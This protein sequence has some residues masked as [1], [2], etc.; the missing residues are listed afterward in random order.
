[1]CQGTHTG[2]QGA[3]SARRRNLILGAALSVG[4]AAGFLYANQEVDELEPSRRGP[5]WEDSG[6]AEVCMHCSTHAG[7]ALSCQIC[8]CRSQL[9]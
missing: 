1:M 9:Q 2:L 4:T 5:D 7:S 8:Q 3:A 6:S